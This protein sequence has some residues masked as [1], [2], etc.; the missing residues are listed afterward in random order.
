MR[1]RAW[2]L[3]LLALA[4]GGLAC[5]SQPSVD[6][7]A[8]SVSATLTAVAPPTSAPAPQ[9]TALL[10]PSP[11]P[12][13][14]GSV[15]GSICYP[16]EGIYAMTAYFQDLATNAVVTLPI[17]QNQSSYSLQLPAGRY[18]AYAWLPDFSFAGS[19]SPA[20]PCGLTVACTDHHPL[21]FDV[22]PAGTL[23]GID[24]CDWYGQPGD[25]P[26]PP[27][28]SGPA[29]T[30]TEVAVQP[31]ASGPGNISGHISYPSGGI[32]KLVI[33]AFN[34]NTGFWWWIGT[35]Q[36]QSSYVHADLPAGV[37][38]VVAYYEAGH[39]QA[40]YATGSHQLL[41]VVVKAGETTSGIDL[42]D[43]VSD[44]TYPDEPGSIDYP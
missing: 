33:V 5:G 11:P 30:A 43:W 1:K 12:L 34:I 3:A 42:T 22:T 8:T 13:T 38:H 20:V 9:P 31:T 6:A 32:P 21:A 7:L 27:G 16:A 24:L 28:I 40:G 23:V 36:N 18:L 14:G 25:I 10:E 37:Y 4:A 44:G 39:L 41:D 17:A 19:Y 2:A 35:A 15:S 29:P 26:L